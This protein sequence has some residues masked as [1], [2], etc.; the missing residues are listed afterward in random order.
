MLFDQV[1]APRILSCRPLTFL[2]RSSSLRDRFLSPSRGPTNSCV[3]SVRFSSRFRSAQF[4]SRFRSARFCFCFRPARFCFCFRPARFC[5]CF[6][7]VRFSFRL[8]PVRFSFRLR[9]VRSCWRPARFCLREEPFNANLL[10]VQCRCVLSPSPAT[11]WKFGSASNSPLP[12]RR[13]TCHGCSQQTRQ[14][15]QPGPRGQSGHRRLDSRLPSQFLQ[16]NQTR[17]LPGYS[18]C[19]TTNNRIIAFHPAAFLSH[20]SNEMTSMKFY[21]TCH[22]VAHMATVLVTVATR[23][24]LQNPPS[25][26]TFK[27]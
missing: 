21:E 15:S 1:A 9:Q 6:R 24:I 3:R 14:P 13:F 7:P 19:Q 2:V 17:P 27:K 8:R 25:Q 22:N 16:K 10:T 18:S 20:I 12:V 26:R 5:F 4:C 11:S 23:S